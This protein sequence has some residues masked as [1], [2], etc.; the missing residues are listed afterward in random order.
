M[1]MGRLSW[2]ASLVLLVAFGCGRSESDRDVV[3]TPPT[4]QSAGGSADRVDPPG[5]LELPTHVDIPEPPSQDSAPPATE[6]EGIQMPSDAPL[7]DQAGAQPAVQYASWEEIRSAAS[8]GGTVTVV[9]LWSLSCE[10]CLK[11]FPGLV[12]LQQQRGAKV[13]CISVAV[14]F[15]GRKTRPPE[16][17]EPSVVEFLNE[18]GASAVTNYICR[19]PS[20][21]VFDVNKLVSIPAV[22]IFDQNGDVVKVFVDAGSTL[23]FSYEKDVIPFVEGLLG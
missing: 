18:V 21:D 11:E 23:G 22:L 20:D 3:V 12:R 4:P 6:V 9:D 8:T 1:N 19:T 10:P 7:G 5:E 13:R 16:Y 15:D 17:Y 2:V 14:D